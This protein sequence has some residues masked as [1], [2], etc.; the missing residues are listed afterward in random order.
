MR[1]LLLSA[2]VTVLATTPADLRPA[3]AQTP[4]RDAAVTAVNALGVDLLTKTTPPGA[5]AL[6]SPY[7]IQTALAMTYAGA[8][9]ATRAEM[10]TVLH[11]PELETD[12][13]GGLAALRAELEEVARRTAEGARQSQAPG[14][15][16]DPVTLTV[17]NRL[18]GQEGF[19]FQAPFLTLL[20]E[21]YAAPFESVDF[22]R[23]WLAVRERINGWVEQQTRDR[24]RELI[25]PDG[26]SGDTRLVLVNAISLK[27]PWED[28][29]PKG[30]TQLRPFQ[31]GGAKPA[32]VP[33]M[34]REGRYG[35][36]QRKGFSAVAIP[37]RGGDL[38]FLVLM[39]EAPDALAALEA[40]L[41]AGV[42]AG[43]ANIAGTD[44]ILVLPKLKL[45]PPVLQL[46]QGLQS[47]GLRSAFNLPPGSAN[48][49]RM[50]PRRSNDYLFV[51]E[52]YHRTFLELDE[53]GTEAAAATAVV[54]TRASAAKA[55]PLEVRVDRPFLFAIQHRPSGTCLFLG[56]VSDPRG[57]Q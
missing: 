14:R 9:G 34:R 36:A 13:H 37:Y 45:E 27:A 16:G 18:F 57:L 31:V 32:D 2:L 26:L 48:F 6:I 41:T 39:P 21:T 44:L 40:K 5:N 3:A 51:S 25:P 53:Q 23:Q 28:E 15:T 7:S 46:S 56:R 52:V 49:N 19:E 20:R 12:L 29:F 35:Y 50:A 10:A 47:L 8:D 43:C 4:P 1:C 55:K 54:I 38:Q 22:I 17:A 42:L 24:I 30:G 11:Y 33:T